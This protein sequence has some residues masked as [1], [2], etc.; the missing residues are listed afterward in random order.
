M[1]NMITENQIAVLLRFVEA[2]L[3]QAGKRGQTASAKLSDRL[4]TFA[5]K[6]RLPIP[7]DRSCN[8]TPMKARWIA[9]P[10][11]YLQKDDPRYATRS[12]C[13]RIKAVLLAQACE[14]TGVTAPD[15]TVEAT[16]EEAL[17]RPP[18]P[19]SANCPQTGQHL[20]LDDLVTGLL[21]STNQVGSAELCIEYRTD[22]RSGGRHEGANVTWVL[23]PR[24]ILS[25]RHLL[26]THGV[27]KSLLSKVQLKAYSTDKQ[28]IP[29]YFSNRDY[30]WATWI[31]S[32]QFASRTECRGVE[33]ELLSQILEFA[34][35]PRL[36]NKDEQKV[37]ADLDR[38]L[39]IG[40][41]KCPITGDAITYSDFV[42]AATNRRAGKSKYHVGHL[43]P[44]TRSG[45]HVK[46]NVVWMSDAGNRIQGNDSFEDIVALIRRAAAYHNARTQSP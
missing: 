37:E 20:A 4:D 35:A 23:P 36:T 6:I 1:T 38:P 43:D 21:I 34:G 7:T 5:C 46:E 3:R 26:T 29:P 22:L 17:A 13:Q 11:A 9:H 42:D 10:H 28:T 39:R 2:Q 8:K 30:R 45:K 33:L 14:F 41:R 15:R 32:P 25:L 16:A 18:L 27:P 19:G 44:I 24:A 40:D 31:Q 12:E